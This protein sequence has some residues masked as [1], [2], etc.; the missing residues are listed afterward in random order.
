ML[1]PFR[2]M[3]LAPSPKPRRPAPVA[4][5]ARHLTVEE[6]TDEL[7]ISPFFLAQLVRAGHIRPH[8]VGRRRLFSQTAVHNLARQL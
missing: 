7:D 3:P 8:R 6:V 4:V 1:E 5:S 2:P